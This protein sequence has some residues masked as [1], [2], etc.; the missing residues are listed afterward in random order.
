M[1]VMLPPA[2]ARKRTPTST[3]L[4]SPAICAGAADGLQMVHGQV[5]L[6]AVVKDQATLSGSAL[7]EA[8]LTPPLPP[9]I[10]AVYVVSLLS[11]CAGISVATLVAAL[12]PTVPV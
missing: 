10:V 5:I 8:S 11:A 1:P 2:S 6:V 12:Y 3:A 7:P 4:A 9:T